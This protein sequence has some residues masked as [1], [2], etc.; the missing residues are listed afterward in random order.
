MI[1]RAHITAWRASAPWTDDAQ[2]EQDLVLSRA[3]IELFRE[4]GLAGR[5][6]LRGGTALNKLFIHPAS[7]YSD[8][9][10]LVQTEAGLIGPVLDAIRANLD[11]WLGEPKR[12]W[13]EGCTTLTY[14]FESEIE[15]VRPLRLKI[16][17]NTREHFAVLGF[18]RRQLTVDNAWFTGSADVVTYELDELIGTKLRALYQRRKGRDLFDLWLCTSGQLIDPAR[19]VRCFQAYMEHGGHRVS[20]AEFEQN[21][22]HKQADPAFLDD[23]RP[24]I[25]H[26]IGY[27][28]QAAIALVREML[29][30]RLPGDPWR[31]DPTSRR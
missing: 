8:D 22:H 24:L 1:P 15:P 10:D 3:A 18:R 7:R 30:Q 17:I 9:V 2:V 16:E 13:A 5:I 6:A 23:I 14:R 4:P 11:P 12:A 25:Q 26:D 21:L 27:D 28:A 19:V 29:I 31:G 20:R